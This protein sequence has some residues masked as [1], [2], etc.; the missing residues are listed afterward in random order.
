[1]KT[2]SDRVGWDSPRT[3]PQDTISIQA[4]LQKHHSQ[5]LSLFD[6]TL[7]SFSVNSPL[8]RYLFKTALMLELPGQ[9]YQLG[10]RRGYP[11]QLKGKLKTKIFIIWVFESLRYISE[12]LGGNTVF[13]AVNFPRKRVPKT[14]VFTSCFKLLEAREKSR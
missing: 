9:H 1:M 7:G 3:C 13:K 4:S 14:P 8:C 6:W 12:N 2:E 11:K 5:S 10:L